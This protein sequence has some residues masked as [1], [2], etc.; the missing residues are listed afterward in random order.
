MQEDEAALVV[1][2]QPRSVAVGVAVK[3][4]AVLEAEA[5]EEFALVAG[6][7]AVQGVEVQLPAL[8]Q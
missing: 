3:V 2:A 4:V 1:A 6:K 8:E 7:G 5:V